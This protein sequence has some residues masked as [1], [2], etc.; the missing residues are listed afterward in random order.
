MD[1]YKEPAGSCCGLP[2]DVLHGVASGVFPE[3]PELKGVVADTPA[4]QYLAHYPG[5]GYL[6]LVSGHCPGEHV[7]LRVLGHMGDVLPGEEQ[8]PGGKPRLVN[9][10]VP[11]SGAFKGQGA[12]YLLAYTGGEHV[13]AVGLVA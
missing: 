2:V 11:P 5:V 12:G 6:Y 10:E 4:A 9:A 1:V 8:V 13:P 7:K 3:A